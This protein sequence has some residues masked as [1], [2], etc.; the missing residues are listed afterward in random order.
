MSISGS[1]I[2]PGSI[3]TAS[4]F[5]YPNQVVTSKT[6][7]QVLASV[8]DNDPTR[9]NTGQTFTGAPGADCDYIVWNGTDWSNVGAGSASS[10]TVTSVSVTSANGFAGSVANPTSTP[11]I[12]LSTTV[13]SPVLAG[14]GTSISAATTTGSGSTVALS[15]SPTFT[16]TPAAPTAAD[17]TNTTQIATTQFVQ[18]AIAAAVAAGS[19]FRGAYDA[20]GNVFPSSGGSGP[21]GTILSGDFWLISVAGTLGGVAVV[22]GDLLYAVADSP[23]QTA[24]NWQAVS[25]EYGYVPENIAN[26]ST[27]TALGNSD[28]LYPSQNAVKVYADTKQPLDATLTALA[29]L[30]SSAGYLVQTAAD[31]F[32][33]RTLTGTSNQV[34]ITNGDGTTGN[35]TFSLPQS[36]ATSSTPSFAGTTNTGAGGNA[37]S[38]AINHTTITS[39]YRAITAK[40]TAGS[41]ADESC[42][43]TI[44]NNSTYGADRFWDISIGSGTTGN[45]LTLNDGQF[46]LYNGALRLVLTKAGA[47]RLVNYG[48]GALTADS[49]GNV[50]STAGT[51]GQV[52]TSNGAG[53]APTF[54]AVSGRLLNTQVFTSSGTYTP[55]AGTTRIIAWGIGAGGGGGGSGTASTGNGGN[56]SGNTSLGSLLVLGGGTGGQ[57]NGSTRGAGGTVGTATFGTPGGDGQ[58]GYGITGSFPGADGGAGFFGVGTRGTVSGAGGAGAAN[59][60]AGGAGGGG[61][62]TWV[63]GSGGGSGAYGM[64]Y[65]TGITGT[66]AVTIAT[67][68]SAGTAGTSGFAGG[69][70]GSGVIVIEEYS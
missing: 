70:G 9:T 12:T 38:D 40:N 25:K 42:A 68:G 43:I 2:V 17:G 19:S 7:F 28:T 27:N 23:G 26:K 31:T 33:K 22:Q 14:N 21:A 32:A 69:A 45:G 20:S 35:P 58:Q 39:S 3:T 47:L 66:Y 60:G 59:T 13:N 50:S 15:A 16:G 51:S 53:V 8:T 41:S 54:Q 65:A 4:D 56:A 48:A 18:T 37:A 24:S 34:I 29:A 52:F 61:G 10:G 49:S 30:D 64:V 57:G 1:P 46:Y 36:I 11:A 62:A 67:G 5:P 6:Q 55:T 44:S 63:S